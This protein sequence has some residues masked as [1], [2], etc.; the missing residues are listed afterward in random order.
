MHE[1]LIGRITGWLA[2]W[3]QHLKFGTAE[4]VKTAFVAYLTAFEAGDTA[5]LEPG[6]VDTAFGAYLRAFGAG[7]TAFL[8]PGS[9]DTAFGA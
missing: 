9:V 7:D 3:K 6:A 8:E 1:F 4:V 5:C 2:G